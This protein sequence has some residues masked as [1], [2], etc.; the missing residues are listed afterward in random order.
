MF[1][2]SIVESIIA[3]LNLDLSPDDLTLIR[4][5]NG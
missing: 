3:N 4:E 1:N 2:K 5:F